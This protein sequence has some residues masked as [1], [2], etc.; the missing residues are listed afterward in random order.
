MQFRPVEMNGTCVFLKP[1]LEQTPPL[2]AVNIITGVLDFFVAVTATGSNAVI[3]YVIWKNRSLHSPSNTLLACLAVTDLLV[4][5][6]VA[7]LNILTKLGEVVK[8]EDIYCVA[9]VMNSFTGYTSGTSTFLI[10]ALISVEK[11]LAIRLHLRYATIITIKTV[12]RVVTILWLLVISLASLRFWDTK[13]VFFRPVLIMGTALSTGVVVFCC[14]NIFLHVRRHRQQILNHVS[15]SMNTR[16]KKVCINNSINS[17]ERKTLIRQKKS[18]LTM[19]YILLFF[20][21]CYFPVFVYQVVAAIAVRTGE[22]S[23]SLR[24]TY[25][26]AFTLAE[27]NSSLNPALYCLRIAE[28]REALMKVLKSAIKRRT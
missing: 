2:F 11:Y 26:I 21:L 1:A 9:G 28:L 4:G 15:V 25:R 24:V 10:L 14:G 27:V 5:S 23:Q 13:E 7:P 18:T 8:Y 22:H 20:F 3:I 19:V 16:N 12:L 6:L 17:E